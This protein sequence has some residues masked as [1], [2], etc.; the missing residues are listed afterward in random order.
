M[1]VTGSAME[2]L[3]RAGDVLVISPNAKTNP[4]DRVVIKTTDGQMLAKV[5]LR[6]T[7]TT[8]EL[9]SITPDEQKTDLPLKDIDW[10]ARIIWA[11][12]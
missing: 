3:Y 6:K 5:L 1:P 2:P 11:S 10:L 7:S 8:I 9:A 12:Q 4:H